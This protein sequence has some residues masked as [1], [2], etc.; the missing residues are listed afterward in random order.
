MFMYVCIVQTTN[1]TLVP[2]VRLQSM[3]VTLNEICFNN[4]IMFTAL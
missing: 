3:F 1:K 2:E 4:G